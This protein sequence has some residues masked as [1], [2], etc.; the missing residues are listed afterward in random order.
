MSEGGGGEEGEGSS[1]LHYIFGVKERR[2]NKQSNKQNNND[3]KEKEGEG[4][5]SRFMATE[6]RKRE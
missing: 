4:G 2:K 6:G 1:A 3:N 5:S